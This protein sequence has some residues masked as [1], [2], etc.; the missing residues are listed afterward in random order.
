MVDWSTGYYRIYGSIRHE[1]NS[2]TLYVVDGKVFKLYK[3][4]MDGQKK[5][6]DILPSI[7]HRALATHNG[8]IY[9]ILVWTGGSLINTPAEI[10]CM[11]Q[12]HLLQIHANH[13]KHVMPVINV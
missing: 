6:Y 2:D 12:P 3:V 13:G 10:I 7:N 8:V 5:E 1:P 11:S 4:F 9:M